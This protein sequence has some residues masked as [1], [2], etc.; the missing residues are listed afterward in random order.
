MGSRGED[1]KHREGWEAEMRMESRGEDGKPAA[2]GH[3]GGWGQSWA[4]CPMPSLWW[5]H[6]AKTKALIIQGHPHRSFTFRHK[7]SSLCPLELGVQPHWTDHSLPAHAVPVPCT[8]PGPGQD[9]L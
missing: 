9:A 4:S 8:V 5:L 7:S 2:P 6:T 1:G 3:S